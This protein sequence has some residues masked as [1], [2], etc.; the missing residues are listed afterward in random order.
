MAV[1][2]LV[3]LV[4]RTADAGLVTVL[5][6]LWERRTLELALRS[7]GLAA[8]VSATC[9]VIGVPVAWLIARTD[10][11][12]GRAWLA[13]AALPLAIPSY[14]SAFAWV[15]TFPGFSGAPAAWLVLTVSC[16]PYVVLPVTAVLAGIDGGMVDAARSL[17]AGPI[18]TFWRVVVPTAAPAAIA[19]ALLSALYVLSDFGAVSLL[20]FDTFTRAIYTSYRASFDRTSA[21]VFALV[22]VILALIFIL[23]ERRFRGRQRRWRVG[24][25]APR[26]SP[27]QQLGVWRVPAVT[28]LVVLYGVALAFP[29]AVL[30]RLLLIGSP[31]WNSS[32]WVSATLNTTTAAGV[33]AALAMVL[34][35]PVGVLA[36]RYRDRWTRWVESSA[37][38]GHALPGVVVG[39]SL[40]YLG[41]A[42]VPALYQSL[43]LLG[44]AYAVLFLSNAIGSVRSA[45][46]RVPPL[47][48]DVG[49]TQGMS[50][51]AMW[52][53]VTLPLTAP[54]LAAGALLVL[55]TAMKELPAT[56]M[57]RPTGMDTLATELWTRTSVSAYA[58]A[59]PY[60]VTL[61]VLAAIPAFVLT[62]VLGRQEAR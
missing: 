23:I 31:E 46:E 52:W 44:F 62:R 57:L 25:G 13:V 54:G 50:A 9:V 14:V 55:L 32:E 37:F 38:V 27:R 3:Y 30:L 20:R 49:R 17:G 29:A 36:A 1:T 21:A 2:P 15:A 60:A 6:V 5:D 34:A 22:L 12:G 45:T 10:L 47:L 43:L 59:A 26:R 16:L 53:R 41:L 19:G 35:V 39:L 4:V 8:A 51:P 48:E 18:G 61:I 42:V 11:P 28:A 24:S 40:V 58:A 7:L 56:L 33:G